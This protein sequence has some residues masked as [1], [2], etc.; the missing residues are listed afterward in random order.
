MAHPQEKRDLVRRKYIFENQS[1][2]VAAMFCQVPFATARSW[3]YQAREQGDDWDKARS[4]NLFAS[5]GIETM[6][7]TLLAGFLVQY[8]SAF[9]DLEKAEDVNPLEKAKVLA[10]LTDSYLKVVNANKKLLPETQ[11]AAVALQVVEELLNH[12]SENYPN[13]LQDFALILQTFETV[14]ER[15]F[16]G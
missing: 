3:K 15:K 16:G 5:G 8:Q 4:A 7:Q 10:S 9:D 6:G 11:A 2:E 1:L 12:I 14:I 13:Q